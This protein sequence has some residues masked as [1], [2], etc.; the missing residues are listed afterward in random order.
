MHLMIRLRKNAGGCMHVGEYG[1]GEWEMN[2]G[3]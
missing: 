1:M 2:S 3:G